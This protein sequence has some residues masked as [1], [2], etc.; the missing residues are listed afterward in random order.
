[1]EHLGGVVLNTTSGRIS[2]LGKPGLSLIVDDGKFVISA[3]TVSN[4][5]ER[6]LLDFCSNLIKEKLEKYQSKLEEAIEKEPKDR[7]RFREKF[8]F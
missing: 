2:G 5:V 1:M 8:I 4:E 6:N 3:G 7:L